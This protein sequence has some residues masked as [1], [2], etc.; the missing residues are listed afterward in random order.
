MTNAEADVYVRPDGET[1]P[2]EI[3]ASP[4]MDEDVVRGAV[5][6]FRDVTQRR[7][8][9]RMKNEFLSVVSHELRTPLTSIRG[10]LGLLA[11][12]TLGDLTPRAQS[13]ASIALESTERLTRLIND[14]LDL[15]R[16]ETGTRP[17]ELA[18]IDAAELLRAS[19][20]EM[21]GFAR[22]S[23]IRVEIGDAPGRVLADRD[24][25]VQTLTN[26]L[27]NAIKFSAPGEH[28]ASRHHRARLRGR[29]HRRRRRP[30]HPRGQA[31][32]HLRAVRAGRLLRRPPEGRHRP[33]PGHQPRHRRAARRPDLGRERGRGRHDGPVLAAQVA[34]QPQPTPTTTTPDAP[35]LLV[36][37]DDAPT[38]ELFSAMLRRHGYRTLG[39]TDGADAITRA[40]SDQPAAVLL[41]LRMP[42][43]TGAEVLAE[44]KASELT[45]HIPVIVVS[46]LS[47]ETEPQVDT[48]AADWLIKPVTEERLV[49]DRLHDARPPRVS[50]A[51]SCSSRTTRTSPA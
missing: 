10:S 17:M 15:E 13:M 6:V 22:D 3:T 23:A 32:G 45:R 35:L 28:R 34:P 2:V 33:R 1:F 26:L 50:T 5:V 43:T 44:L 21:A 46:G 7:E 42:G 27:G 18:A 29:V 38:V 20:K 9:D 37:D 11:G 41:D 48:D 16:I 49:A 30:R 47:P 12:G 4:L 25:I 36:C 8:V 51:S 24:R 19:A 14:I 40:I 31:R 39:V